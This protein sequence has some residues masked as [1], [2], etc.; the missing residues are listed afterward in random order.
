MK[1]CI[2][3][4]WDGSLKGSLK[5]TQDIKQKDLRRHQVKRYL[6][7]ENQD[8]DRLK[9]FI[10]DVMKPGAGPTQDTILEDW[11][12]TFE[13]V[14]DGNQ[15]LRDCIKHETLAEAVEQGLQAAGAA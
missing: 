2:K 5:H 12:L 7:L 15:C 13:G 4:S 11:I 1:E 14:I 3:D 8:L 9:R 10:D 6:K